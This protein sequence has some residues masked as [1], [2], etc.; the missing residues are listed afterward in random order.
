MSQT[1]TEPK[2]T[3]SKL[4]DSDGQIREGQLLTEAEAAVFDD[5]MFESLEFNMRVKGS[6]YTSTSIRNA[7]TYILTRYTMSLR[8]NSH[9][10]HEVASSRDD[11][12]EQDEQENQAEP[13]ETRIEDTHV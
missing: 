13:Q 2:I 9:D 8:D 5:P 7:L 1:Q 10:R 3:K 4:I 12:S 11:Q 6:Y